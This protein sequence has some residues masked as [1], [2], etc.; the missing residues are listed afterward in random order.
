MLTTM[1]PQMAPTQEEIGGRGGVSLVRL[2]VWR[3]FHTDSLQSWSEP[4]PRDRRTQTR[5]DPQSPTQ[6]HSDSFGVI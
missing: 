6:I 1:K 2:R 3:L 4:H 5:S